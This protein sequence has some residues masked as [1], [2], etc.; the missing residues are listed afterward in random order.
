MAILLG[1]AV[2]T[3]VLIRIR[4]LAQRP[5]SA[6]P[7]FWATWLNQQGTAPDWQTLAPVWEGAADEQ[8][9]TP[10]PQDG[11]PTEWTFLYWAS[12]A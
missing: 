7:A 11:A 2:P 6:D 12:S 10:D 9:G 5:R 1:W 4:D 3:P 8:I